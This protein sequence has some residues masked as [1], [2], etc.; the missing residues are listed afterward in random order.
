MVADSAAAVAGVSPLEA[1]KQGSWVKLI[2]GASF[3]DAIEVRSLALIY[4][5]AGVDCIDCACDSAIVTAVEE[6]ISAAL[7]LFAA[8][9]R[10]SQDPKTPKLRRPLVM[11]SLNDDQDPHFRKAVF[12]AE[13]CPSDCPRPCETICPAAAIDLKL[14]GNGDGLQTGPEKTKLEGGVIEERC[15][16]CG[17]CI[18]V[19]PLGLIEARNYVRPPEAVAALLREGRVD[20]VEVHTQGRD[21]AA[22]R[23]LWKKLGPAFQQLKLVAVSLPEPALPQMQ[24]MYDVMAPWLLQ[25]GGPVL[26]W[27]LDGRPM[28]GDI[29]AGAT[30]AACRLAE[31]VLQDETRPPG[32]LQLAG[33]TNGHTATSM[34][35]AGVFGKV[36]GVA[37][38]GYA[39]K[40]LHPLL[41]EAETP[42]KLENLFLQLRS[43]RKV[44][45]LDTLHFLEQPVDEATALLEPFRT[46]RENLHF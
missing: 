42:R 36:A 16:G 17:R 18:N 28:S 21:P 39:R 23:Q 22:F 37:F 34:Q 38:G 6:G 43:G 11:V 40:I 9:L 30:R 7:R 26:V 3:E 24:P 29:G 5:L 2:C 32:F 14:A 13:L 45:D 10:T 33:G 44:L 15:Y 12:D 1:L 4:T 27:Q 25:Q 35:R 46:P 31:K 8:F 19:C 41:S 20:A